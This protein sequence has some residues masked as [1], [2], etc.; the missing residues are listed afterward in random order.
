LMGEGWMAGDRISEA[1]DPVRLEIRAALAA[2]EAGNLNLIPIL[3]DGAP[4]PSPELLPFDVR[5]IRRRNARPLSH[6]T[7]RSDLED[8]AKQLG[9]DLAP[10]EGSALAVV[11]RTLAGGGIALAVVFMASL[12]N[13]AVLNQSLETTL[14]GQAALVALL[15]AIVVIGL[16]T[17][18]LLSWARKR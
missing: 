10:D 18:N 1:R 17:P 7:F 5:P 9:I 11:G 2:A 15:V 16:A 14:G 4:M 3:V 6:G 8:L 12:I 13:R